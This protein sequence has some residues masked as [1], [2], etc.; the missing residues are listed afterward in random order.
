MKIKNSVGGGNN[1]NTKKEAS[2]GGNSK[3]STVREF[4]ASAHAV[5]AFGSRSCN[6]EHNL[7]VPFKIPNMFR[8]RRR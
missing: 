4:L 3:L 2:Q 1:C 8:H 6:L 5:P 7:F